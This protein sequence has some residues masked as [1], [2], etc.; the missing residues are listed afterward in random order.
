MAVCTEGALLVHSVHRDQPGALP[1]HRIAPLAQ[2]VDRPK[3]SLDDHATM[4]KKS[5]FATIAKTSFRR[6]CR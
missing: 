2:I 4:V 5:P 6:G 3:T 1:S